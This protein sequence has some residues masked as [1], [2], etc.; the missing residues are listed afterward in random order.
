MIDGWKNKSNNTKQVSVMIKPRFQKEIF[1]KAFDFSTKSENAEALLETVN[2]STD[3]A[4]EKFNI[5]SYSFISDHAAAELKAG[6]DSA[7]INYGC[8]AHAGN[9]YI[10]DVR[11]KFICLDVR[12]IMVIFRHP[13]MESKLKL[14]GGS[15]I[16]LAGATRWKGTYI[17]WYRLV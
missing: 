10:K 17:D 12:D 11:D 6:E 7:L 16:Y 14:L 8:F 3:I 9:L 13:Q 5:R 15:G 1:V 2:K 4:L